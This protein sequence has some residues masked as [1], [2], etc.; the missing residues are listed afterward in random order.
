MEIS[1]IAKPILDLQDF[2]LPFIVNL[3]AAPSS[4]K[5]VVIQLLKK[6]FHFFIFYNVDIIVLVDY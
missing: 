6:I 4:M 3:V 2:N 5:T 1:L